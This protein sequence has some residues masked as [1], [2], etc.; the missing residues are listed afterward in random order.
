MKCCSFN[1]NGAKRNLC[2]IQSIFDN[3]DFIYLCETWL[4]DSE[5]LEFLNKLSPSHNIIHKADTCLYL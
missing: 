2:F 5:S 1:C 4:L 3:N